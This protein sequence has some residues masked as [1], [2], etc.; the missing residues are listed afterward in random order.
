MAASGWLAVPPGAPLHTAL[1]VL[2]RQLAAGLSVPAV[3]LEALQVLSGKLYM[4]I[5]LSARCCL[6]CCCPGGW[7]AR[8]CLHSPKWSSGKMPFSGGLA[9][10]PRGPPNALIVARAAACCKQRNVDLADGWGVPSA[11]SQDEAPYPGV[12]KHAAIRCVARMG[13]QVT[14]LVKKV[15]CEVPHAVAPAAH[16]LLQGQ[17]LM[18]MRDLCP[19]R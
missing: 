1:Q 14:C 5:M 2:L 13:H 10:E 16:C 12:R 11:T 3:C 6:W 8:T 4:H 18:N 7:Q 17:E 19:T 15:D 9:P